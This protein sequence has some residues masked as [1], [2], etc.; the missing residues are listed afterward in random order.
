MK[1]RLLAAILVTLTCLPILIFTTN[2]TQRG[3]LVTARDAA[4]KRAGVQQVPDS[5][6]RVRHALQRRGIRPT[7]ET[8]A[9]GIAV[10]LLWVVVIAAVGRR[11]FRLRL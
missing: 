10:Q 5:V 4:F 6:R 9:V 7:F 8:A 3:P 1:S 11:W 2:A